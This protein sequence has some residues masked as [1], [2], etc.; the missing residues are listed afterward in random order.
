[1]NIDPDKVKKLVLIF[2]E[3][4]EEYQNK[5]LVEAFRLELMQSQKK[6]IKAENKTF[7]TEKELETEIIKRSNKT[8]TEAV[9]IME[10]LDKVG[11]TEKA[12]FIIM[13]NQ[14]AGKANSVEESD[15]S[16]TINK[17][18]ITMK[19]YLEKNLVNADYEK[20]KMQVDKFMKEYEKEHTQLPSN[21]EDDY[22]NV[23]NL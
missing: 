23:M 13:V 6:H 5:L 7:K 8:A 14:L 1:M 2:S 9:Q 12:I 4:D 19:E 10:K 11:D 16:I 20:A 3:L 21:S 15:I 17:K 22:Y 18:E